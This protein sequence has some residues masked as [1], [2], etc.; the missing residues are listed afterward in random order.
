MK[1]LT[2]PDKMGSKNET[3]R[4]ISNICFVSIT[5]DELWKT[6]P[7]KYIYGLQMIAIDNKLNIF[8]PNDYNKAMVKLIN[9]ICF[10]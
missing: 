7:I 5:S 3:L 2:S 9:A 8:E 4:T 6:E 10:N 1:L